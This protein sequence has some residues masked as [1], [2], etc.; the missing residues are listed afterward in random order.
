MN[1]NKEVNKDYWEKNIEGFSGF[2]DTKSEENIIAIPG[3]GF[4]YKRLIFPIEKKYMYQ[5]HKYVMNYINENVKDGM[6]VADIGCGSGIYVKKM[7]EMGAFVYAYDYVKS[8]VNLTRKNL[9][10]LDSDLF[11]VRQLD[12]TESRIEDVDLAISVG[13]LTYIDDLD[14]YFSNILPFTNKFMFNYL[15]SENTINS[16]RRKIKFLDVRDYSYHSTDEII[17]S[18]SRWDFRVISKEKLAT[19]HIIQSKKES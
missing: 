9:V 10:G 17:N 1:K 16:I 6:K 7:V 11:E 3:F 2:Y 5:R 12:I 14:K 15:D 4:L 8:A 13:V 18:M 19:G